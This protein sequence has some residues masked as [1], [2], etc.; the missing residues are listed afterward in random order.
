M[1]T[2]TLAAPMVVLACTP[3]P[4]KQYDAP[5]PMTIDPNKRY[6]ATLHLEK[7]DT[8]VEI[9]LFAKEAPSTVNSFVFLAGDGY[10]D[11]V[12]FHRVIPGFMAQTGDPTG[13]GKGGPG[14]R[15]DNEFAANRRHDAAGVVSMANSGLKNGK[16]TNGSQFFITYTP[17]PGLDGL[18]QD[19]SP[20]DCG[21]ESCHTVF[22]R[23]I[24]GMEF[25]EQITSRD[26]SKADFQGDRIKTIAVREIPATASVP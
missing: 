1:L 2:L 19:G 18:K 3:K 17:Q 14:Y 8:Q 10:Y 11:N 22:G 9:E 24:S 5:P 21:K 25:V 23:V 13:T 16:G 4:E 12:T 20:K 26:P 7:E 6:V 15:F